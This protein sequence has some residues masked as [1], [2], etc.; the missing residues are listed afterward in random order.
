[1]KG[2][3]ILP[4]K[5]WMF[6]IKWSDDPEPRWEPWHNI[7]SNIKVHEFLLSKGLGK[8]IPSQYQ[9]LDK[10]QAT[11]WQRIQT[12]LKQTQSTAKLNDEII[13]QQKSHRLSTTNIN[14]PTQQ[15]IDPTI[16]Q[17]YI[18]VTYD[19]D[20]YLHEPF[21]DSELDFT[22]GPLSATHFQTAAQT[23]R[24]IYHPYEFEHEEPNDII[25]LE[26]NQPSCMEID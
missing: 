22:T 17:I 11:K 18:L 23:R 15:E 13:I 21:H 14:N 2:N 6:K 10:T 9:H 5:K 7:R 19:E 24:P 12:Q 8:H 16:D 1:M 4:H 3:T 26:E 25:I 20:I